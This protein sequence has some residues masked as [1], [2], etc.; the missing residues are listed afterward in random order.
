MPTTTPQRV[1]IIGAG[2]SG[3]AIARLA[4]AAGIPVTV[5]SSGPANETAELLRFVAPGAVAST[6]E[7]LPVQVDIVAVPFP[8]AGSVT[9][10]CTCWRARSSP[11]WSTH[12][13]STPSRL[14]R[15]SAAPPSN[16]AQRCSGTT[17]TR[18][19]CDRRWNSRSARRRRACASAL[20][21]R[22]PSCEPRRHTRSSRRWSQRPCA[23][24]ATSSYSA[25]AAAIAM[26]AAVPLGRPGSGVRTAAG[27]HRGD[28]G[29][30]RRQATRVAARYAAHPGLRRYPVGVSYCGRR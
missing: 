8:C 27:G 20:T 5:A 17:S 29:E 28:I 25:A 1:G 6:V 22:A 18:T 15:S 13:A 4:L 21:I 14:G 19:P 30:C 7:E 3:A 23:T 12:S 11:S 16:P 2:K 26:R 9:F 24:G 10:P